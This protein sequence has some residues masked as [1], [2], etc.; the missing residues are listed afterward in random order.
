M[1]ISF[2]AIST[3]AA[4]SLWN[5]GPDS[6]GLVPEMNL[7]DGSGL[8]C[9]HCLKMIPEG[10]PYLIAA[11]R[12]FET[13]NPYTETGPVFVCKEPCQRA[14]QGDVIPES[15][16]SPTYIVRGYTSNERIIYG[17]GSVTA[18][19]DIRA[20]TA[21]LLEDESVAFVH[22]RSASNNCF[23]VRIDRANTE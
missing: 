1:Q 11:Y 15:M 5:G 16:D 12:P 10:K 18:T 20:K 4:Q 23:H 7:S 17:T 9:R 2:N 13:L 8:P 3:S 21:S 6:Y 22:V 19:E 14:V